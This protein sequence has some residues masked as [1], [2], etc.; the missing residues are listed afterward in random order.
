MSGESFDYTE[1]H[2]ADIIDTIEE[3]IHLA[4]CERPPLISENKVSVGVYDTYGYLSYPY[5][6]QGFRTLESAVK[7][8]QGLGYVM[9]DRGEQSGEEKDIYDYD[10][11]MKNPESGI[12]V[13]I[14]QYIYEHYAPDENGDVPWYPDCTD[15]TIAELRCGV[16]ALKRAYVYAHRIAY[17]ISGDDGENE[18]HKRLKK[19][20]EDLEK[21]ECGH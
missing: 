2:I 1:H 20:L 13:R 21:E 11:K 12:I 15:E 18:F 6:Y 16:K 4:T 3:H 7:Y 14:R 8:F 5:H 17:L 10:A 19:E 9:Q